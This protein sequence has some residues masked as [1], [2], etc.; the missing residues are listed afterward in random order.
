MGLGGVA[1][2]L[3]A[4]HSEAAS[5]LGERVERVVGRFAE[6]GIDVDSPFLNPGSTDSYEAFGGEDRG[7]EGESRRVR[8]EAPAGSSI[9]GV[10]ADL[11]TQRSDL[12][13]A[14]DHGCV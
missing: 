5:S 10:D 8:L 7:L 9:V 3:I 2:G 14:L 11:V 6:A 1:D 12:K 4:A 13:G